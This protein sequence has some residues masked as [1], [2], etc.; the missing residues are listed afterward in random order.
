MKVVTW[1]VN[2]INVR[3]DRL[4][5]L[6]KREDPD[7]VCLQ[8]LKCTE[9]KFPFEAL[10]E[11]GFESLVWGQKTYNGVAILSKTKPSKVWKGFND[12]SFDN[13]ARMIG[14][15]IDGLTVICVYV[16]NGQEVGSDKYRY[17]L[18]WFEKLRLF[19]HEEVDLNLPVLLCGDFNV[20]P[21]DQDVYDPKVWRDQIL[22]S[23]PEKDALRKITDLGLQD[24]YRAIHP[25]GEAFTWWD[26]RNI[27][28]PKN[29]GLRIDFILG[30]PLSVTLVEDAYVDRNERKGSQP[31][32]HAPVVCLFKEGFHQ[33]KARH[34]QAQ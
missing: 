20:A 33:K 29:H 14:A 3:L 4:T 28:F 18:K 31:S 19:L 5:K 16:P 10:R 23:E 34:P 25:E 17:K 26:Y 30:S 32:D 11:K 6:L 1:N 15:Q 7:V 9:D 2:S 27:S 21:T 8:E 12:A 24:L 13:E 22:F